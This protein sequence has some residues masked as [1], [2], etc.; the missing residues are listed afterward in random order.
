MGPLGRGGS[1]SEN[2]LSLWGPSTLA[3]VGP[4]GSCAEFAVFSKRSGWQGP[5]PPSPH[6]LEDTPLLLEQFVLGVQTSLSTHSSSW[7]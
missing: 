1:P 4:S 3:A 7:L 5:A 6:W 2:C